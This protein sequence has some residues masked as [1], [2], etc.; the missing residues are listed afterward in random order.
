MSKRKAP[1]CALSIAFLISSNALYGAAPSPELVVSKFQNLLTSA[2][3]MAN[4]TAPKKRYQLLAP[5]ID[6][7]FHLPLMTKIVTGNRWKIANPESRQQLKA[8]FRR[9]S[10]SILATLFDSYN[11]EYFEYIKTIEGPSNTKLVITNLVKADKSRIELLYV[12]HD[13]E[14]GWR[15]IDVI[16][17]KGISE[18]KVRKSEYRQILKKSGFEGLTKLLNTKAQNLIPD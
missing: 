12:T 1:F 13:F 3:K 15:I 16:V 5:A 2:M 7:A 4:T 9:M 14:G 10:A 11:G 17:D 6:S 8:A 18:L